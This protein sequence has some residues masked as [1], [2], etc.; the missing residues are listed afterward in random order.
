MIELRWVVHGE[1]RQLHYRF[2]LMGVEASGAM[3]PGAGW[4]PWQS[5]PEISVEEMSYE[6]LRASG[7]IV[8]A[9]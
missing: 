6:D 2:M 5:V 7:G 8:G 4:S 9:P 3:A 1:N